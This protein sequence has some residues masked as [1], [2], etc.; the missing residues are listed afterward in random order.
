MVWSSAEQKL[1]E[2]TVDG[3]RV[4][5]A[6][7]NAGGNDKA[8]EN[9]VART[10][11]W[12]CRGSRGKGHKRAGARRSQDNSRYDDYFTAFFANFTSASPKALHYI[13]GRYEDLLLLAESHKDQAGTDN[14]VNLLG[15]LGWQCTASPAMQSDKSEVGNVSG[16]IAGVRRN[17]DNRPLSICSDQEGK[18]S[19]NPFLT[20][21]MIVI[22]RNEIIALSGY[23][24][25]GG[26]RGINV[27]TINYVDQITRGGK[28]LFMWALDAKLTL[29]PLPGMLSN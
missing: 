11:Q 22:E 9:R 15:S 2:K 27:N 25:G 19:P 23:L 26:L 10:K 28:D 24:E 1:F 14:V 12:T 13:V 18:R 29:P 7:V 21:R 4:W 6:D 17:I 8:E 3:H 20:G 5:N 16:V